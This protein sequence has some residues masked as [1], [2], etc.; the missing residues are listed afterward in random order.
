MLDVGD[1]QQLYWEACGNP[2]G[3]PAVILHGGPGSG[4]SPHY[5]RYF[6]PSAYRIL[7]FDQRGTGRSTP[8][9]DATTDLSVNTT[10][11]LVADI[12]SLRRYFGVE[13]WLV[14]GVSWG[15]TL[16]LVYAERY[17]Q[18][19]LAMVLA[20]VTMTRPRDIHWLY[21][22]TGRF[23]PEEWARFRAGVPE[24]DRDGD[25]VIAYHRL[26]HEQPDRDRQARAAQDW[27]AWEDATQSLEEGWVP[28]PRYQDPA[29]RMTYARL[30][31]HYFF[32]RA[33]LEDGQIL[34]DLH[35][36]VG[37]PGVLIHGHFDL[38][39]P[40]D[41]AWQ[42]AQAWPGA[43]LHL[44]ATGHGGGNAMTDRIVEATT[45]LARP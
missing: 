4:A 45:R 12:E 44:V 30:V 7:L 32:H 16:G 34:R 9:V 41:V 11:H 21:H 38:G 1:G 20:S 13:Q 8:R 15:V 3:T 25:L 42:L 10:E 39:G 43:E 22:E 27:C 29:F 35:R 24:Q 17:P 40:P 36:L 5:R 6:D 37:I 19:V 2:D 33:W 18:R 31:T 23:F 14:W 28:H 26:L